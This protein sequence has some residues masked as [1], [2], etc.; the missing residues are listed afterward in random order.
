MW[1]WIFSKIILNVWLWLIPDI[2]VL[3]GLHLTSCLDLRWSTCRTGLTA[4]SIAFIS[5]INNLYNKK[6]VINSVWEFCL[7]HMICQKRHIYGWTWCKREDFPCSNPLNGALLG[8][9]SC[10]SG[11]GGLSECLFI[12]ISKKK[13]QELNPKIIF[14]KS[15]HPHDSTY[16]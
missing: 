13:T 2:H 4:P 6:M 1:I 7:L 11:P 15:D 14:P 8:W 3:W 16:Y 5:I 10:P 12:K 9:F